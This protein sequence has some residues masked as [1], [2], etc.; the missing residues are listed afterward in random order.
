LNQTRDGSATS[1][2]GVLLL[3]KRGGTS[4]LRGAALVGETSAALVGGIS[5]A[6][7]DYVQIE[8]AK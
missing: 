5:E 7:R 8:Q 2:V 3:W 1:L 6:G 4:A